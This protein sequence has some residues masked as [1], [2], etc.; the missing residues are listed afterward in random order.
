MGAQYTLLS[1]SIDSHDGP[2]EASV[3]KARA[4]RNYDRPQG[5]DGWHLLTSDQST[6]DLLT[7][8]VGFHDLHNQEQAD[9]AHP[10]G[11]VI[12]TPDG[13]ISNY[14]YGIDFASSDLASSLTT[15][16]QNTTG[17]AFD[18][19]LLICYQYDPLTGRNTQFALDAMRF[20]G[21]LTLAVTLIFL[22]KLWRA[23][24]RRGRA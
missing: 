14:L 4:L 12:L 3:F 24:L 5:A 20:G 11:V 22:G 7:A 9:F 15:A 17:S 16:S 23:D 1:V 2:S 10:V 19:V 13:V 18:R 21:A 8:A 6:I